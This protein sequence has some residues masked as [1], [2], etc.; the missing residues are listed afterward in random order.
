[1]IYLLFMESSI[2]PSSLKS[3]D[4]LIYPEINFILT[5]N[6]LPLPCYF[7]FYQKTNLVRENYVLF[8][9]TDTNETDS[10]IT[11]TRK[12]KLSYNF[13]LSQYIYIEL[14]QVVVEESFCCASTGFQ[15]V[16]LLKSPNKVLPLELR[17][18]NNQIYN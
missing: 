11:Y 1:M 3:R 9:A 14:H 7:K 12:I 10:N 13:A 6:K 8:A 15:L 17:Y 2:H 4:S 18:H 5:C 16:D